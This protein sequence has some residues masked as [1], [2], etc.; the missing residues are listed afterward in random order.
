[1]PY[2]LAIGASNG[3]KHDHNGIAFQETY[4][5]ISNEILELT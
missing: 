4:L 5:K 2:E 3:S 1:M